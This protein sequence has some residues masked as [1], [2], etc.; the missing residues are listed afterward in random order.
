MTNHPNPRWRYSKC[1][2][3]AEDTGK[4]VD[5]G[6]EPNYH[7]SIFTLKY[8]INEHRNKYLIKEHCGILKEK[9]KRTCWNVPNKRTWWHPTLK[10]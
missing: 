4:Y 2:T 8:L 6:L 10:K 5:E 9:N 3:R 1:Q 7:S